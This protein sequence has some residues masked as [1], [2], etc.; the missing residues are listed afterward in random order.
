MDDYRGVSFWFDALGEDVRV[1]PALPGPVDV[2]VVILGAGYTGL[3]T[4][5]YLKSL[6]PSLSV[7][8]LEAET[9]GFGA[10]GRNGGWLKGSMAGE[11]MYLSDQPAE[12]R[13][14]GYRLLHGIVDHVRT[15]LDLENIDCG[16]QQGG[17]LF[18]A[19][20][21]PEQLALVRAHLDRL[22]H[23]GH[24]EDDYR[25]LDAQELSRQVRMHKPYGAIF[26][27]HCA[28]VHPGKLV[29]G[30]ARAV[31]RRGAVI[32][33]RT[34]VSTIQGNTVVTDQGVVRAR[35]IVP[36]LEGY[37]GSIS[38]LAGTVLPVQSQIIA[39]EP[40]SAA[41]WDEVG[42]ESRPAF[43]DGGRLITYGQRSDDGRLIFGARGGYRFGARPRNDFTLSG[44]ESALRKKLMV[45]LFPAL[46]NVRVTH[47]W[48]GTMGMARRFAPHAVCD[49]R[50]GIATAGGYGGGGVGAAN[51]F[52]RTLA[53]L[54]LER[55]TELTQM[56]WVVTGASPRRALRRWEPEPLPWLV[57]RAVQ[58]AYTWEENLCGAADAA[59]WRKAL[60]GRISATLSKLLT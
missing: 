32:Y 8:I 54:I 15:V 2:D 58:A 31:E 50:S 26:S 1:R 39:T 12:R 18:A 45:E 4:A 30:L 36:A 38:S 16:F 55:D 49:R 52:G 24:A 46:S 56:P 42:L 7:T 37:A 51:L 29:R 28:V 13:E 22:R 60:A 9:A 10:S 5:Y 27:P 17:V 41:Q 57:Y 43:S 14:T 21:Y 59:P 33:E 48:G 19:A 53:D 47:G 11:D 6:A 20:R 40:L 3:W 34:R 23:A 35:W 44:P 25:W